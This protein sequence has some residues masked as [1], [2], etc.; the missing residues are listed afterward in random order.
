MSDSSVPRPPSPARRTAARAA[1]AGFSLVWLVPILALVVTLGLAWNAFAG[2]G[3]LIE[4]EF[5]DAT[6][7]VP[8]ETTL[9][10]RE[11]TVGKVE[12]VSFTADL[13]NV[14]VSVRVEPEVAPYIDKR[15]GILDRPPASSRP[16]GISRLDTVLTGRLHRRL[17]G[18]QDP[19]GAKDAGSSASPRPTLARLSG[20][21]GHAH[22]AVLAERAKRHG[23]GRADHLPRPSGRPDAEPAPVR[24]GRMAACW[25]MCL[26]RRRMISG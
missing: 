7:I 21:V 26:L 19:R 2:R 10:F 4:I 18:R 11:V 16:Q 14:V 8:G 17:L 9:R 5:S 15:R 3:E 6:G 1:Q 12:S 20:A 13:R 25:P 22:R 23:R 24:D